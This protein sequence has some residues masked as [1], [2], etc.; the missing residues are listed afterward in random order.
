[1]FQTDRN[2]GTIVAEWYRRSEAQTKVIACNA[3]DSAV[4]VYDLQASRSIVNQSQAM[5]RGLLIILALP[6]LQEFVP[7]ALS[8]SRLE[9]RCDGLNVL[10]VA[11]DG[12]AGLV[13]IAVHYLI[14]QYDTD[15]ELVQ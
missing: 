12:H 1:M 3:S 10:H 9:V 5:S 11:L 8:D 15:E 2:N 6:S 14:R 13:P 7:A 4:I